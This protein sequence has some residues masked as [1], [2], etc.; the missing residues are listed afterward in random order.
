MRNLFKLGLILFTLI[1]TLSGCHKAE[2]SDNVIVV[3]T[4]AGPE[5]ALMKVA[6]DVANKR[7]GL[8]IKTIEFTDYVAPNIALNDGSIDANVFQHQPYLDA[9][10]KARGFK[11]AMIGKTFIYP[12]AIYSTRIKQLSEIQP[13]AYVAI[14][15][16]PSN[17][18]RA[19][20]LLQKADLIKL[21]P[22]T[23]ANANLKDI[24]ANPHN[25]KIKELDAAQLP[26]ILPD[27]EL[28]VINTNYA[29]GAKLLPKRDGLALEDASS[30]Y[31][32]IIV[33]RAEDRYDPKFKK[34]IDALHSQEVLDTA[35][36]LFSGQ[37]IPAWE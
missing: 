10:I 29:I 34:L 13:G 35:N 11:L 7:Y 22:N 31:E 16:D 17:E 33:V 5:S 15:N 6:A 20:L 36:K 28:A 8:T 14:P 2:Q 25:L 27:V 9:T 4:I 24:I 1:S 21:K 18:A 26:R 23:G 3:G 37:A 19:L 12:M 30:L 32:N